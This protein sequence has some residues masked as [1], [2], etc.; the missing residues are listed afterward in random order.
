MFENDLLTNFA[1]TDPQTE[2]MRDEEGLL[3]RVFLVLER[4]VHWLKIWQIL[5][6]QHC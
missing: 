4:Q 3:N 2:R 1:T 5:E 6:G